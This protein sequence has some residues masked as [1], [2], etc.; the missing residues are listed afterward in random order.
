M[1]G[2]AERVGVRLGEGGG[3]WPNIV[4]GMID[5]HNCLQHG[6]SATKTQLWVENVYL[7]KALPGF[8]VG[9]SVSSAVKM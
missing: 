3:G 9:P 7:H 1:E 4:L 8:H 5:V 2:D 6:S